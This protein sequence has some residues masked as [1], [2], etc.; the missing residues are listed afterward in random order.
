MRTPLITAVSILFYVD[1][2]L[3]LVGVGFALR[4][5]F[6]HRALPGVGGAR[7][8]S[9]PFESLGMEAFIVAGIVYMVVSAL[10]IMVGYWLWNARLDGA[11]FGLIL[12]GLSAIFWYGFELP[13]GPIIGIVEVILLVLVWSSLG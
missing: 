9:G 13:I 6:V 12:V 1:A 7:A 5:A 11:V 8:L 2:F 10:K 3:W 4:Y